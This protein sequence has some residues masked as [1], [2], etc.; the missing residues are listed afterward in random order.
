MSSVSVF[1]IFQM[2]DCRHKTPYQIVLTKTDL[3][4]P[5]DVARRAMEIQEVLFPVHSVIFT[6]Q[7]IS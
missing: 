5:I 1:D 2:C 4:F 7:F 6:F 3:V